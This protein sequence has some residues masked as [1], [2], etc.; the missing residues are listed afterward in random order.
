MLGTKKI[1][2]P[3]LRVLL[4]SFNLSLLCG[5][6]D[7][8]DPGSSEKAFEMPLATVNLVCKEPT[9]KK[10]R[11]S[12]FKDTA[13]TATSGGKSQYLSRER[14]PAGGQ[15]IVQFKE[16]DCFR[17]DVLYGSP[18]PKEAALKLA[19]T[20]L[21]PDAPPQSRVDEGKQTEQG[22]QPKEVYYFGNDFAV[23]LSF[24]D[25]K[26]HSANQVSEIAAVNL[27]LLGNI[28][29]DQI[30]AKEVQALL[31]KEKQEKEKEEKAKAS[32]TKSDQ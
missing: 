24:K 18:I 6:A 32:R 22:K 28:S 3:L 1:L 31:D 26:D 5:C 8:I 27:E 14:T 21:P 10:A 15:Y 2:Q 25:D 7:I 16:G 20:L 11:L 4:L 13:A 30:A 9:L 29:S 17:I 23:E 19:R 12:F